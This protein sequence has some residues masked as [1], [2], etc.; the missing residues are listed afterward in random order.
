LELEVDADGVNTLDALAG[1]HLCFVTEDPWV[2]GHGDVTLADAPDYD[3]STA[4]AGSRSDASDT[5][6]FDLT[7]HDLTGVSGVAIVPAAD[8]MAPEFQIIFRLAAPAT[9][10]P[11]RNAS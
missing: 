7:E 9:T 10:A 1:L 5:W 4:I 11:E 3:C 2:V 8:A 6:A